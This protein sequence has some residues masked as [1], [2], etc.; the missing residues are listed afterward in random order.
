[1]SFLK[2]Y[3]PREQWITYEQD[4]EYRYLEPYIHEINAEWD[5]MEKFDGFDYW[6]RDWSSHEMK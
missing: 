3:L 2:T 6:K 4:L 1:L 5:E